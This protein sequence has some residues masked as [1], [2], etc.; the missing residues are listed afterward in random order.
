MLRLISMV[1]ALDELV[2]QFRKVCEQ[3]PDLNLDDFFDAD[4]SFMPIGF[5]PH[6]RDL[7]NYFEREERERW[8]DYMKEIRRDY[9]F[10]LVK[11]EPL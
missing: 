2:E 3:N 7:K 8:F 1:E 5:F 4:I 6:I 10:T 9:E 11:K